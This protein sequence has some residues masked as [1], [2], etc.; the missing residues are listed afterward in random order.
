M[1]ADVKTQL[2]RQL[3]DSHAM[4][5]QAL[6][7]LDA[8]SSMIGDEEVARILRAHRMQTGEHERLIAERLEA[9]GEDSSKLKDAAMQAGALGIG[10]LAGAA[11]DTPLRL[12]TVAFAFENFEIAN[13]GILRRLA[14]KA[15]DTDTVAVADRIREQEEAAAELL[16]GT[17][18][19]I[20]ELALGE[21]ARSPL[22]GVT[23]IGKPSERGSEPYQSG[24]PQDFKDKPADASLGQPEHVDSPTEGE[25]LAGPEPGHPADQ[26]EPYGGE[27]PDPEHPESV[28]ATAPDQDEAK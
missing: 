27:V 22:P 17:F 13:Y 16:E 12:A 1:N 11:P 24:G 8:G 20:L 23:P 25:H 5:K 9:H 21:P 15:G 6:R 19:R 26:T 3:T 2:I 7:L 10:M 4:E 28:G 18:D 14:E